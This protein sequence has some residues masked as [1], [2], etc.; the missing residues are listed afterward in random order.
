MVFGFRDLDVFCKVVEL[1][2]FSKAAAEVHLSQASVS[3]RIAAL[4]RH[5]QRVT[6]YDDAFSDRAV[7]RE[8]GGIGPVKLCDPA[9]S[10]GRQIAVTGQPLAYQSP[11][12]LT[13]SSPSYVSDL[14]ALGVLGYRLFL[15]PGGAERALTGQ[16]GEID[17]VDAGRCRQ[18]IDAGE[19]AA[20][21]IEPGRGQGP[22]G[23]EMAQQL[24]AKS[25][26][27]KSCCRRWRSP[28]E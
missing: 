24:A 22:G 8:S 10:L 18:D 2:S 23:V 28:S 26:G 17:E 13:S 20:L 14:H 25:T 27:R 3:E 7:R 15:G 19:H 11:E 5:H 16:D 4:V 6:Q 21:R 9:C 12:I 1:G